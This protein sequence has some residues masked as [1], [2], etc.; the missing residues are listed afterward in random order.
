MVPIATYQNESWKKSWPEGTDADQP[1]PKMDMPKRWFFHDPTISDYQD[2]VRTVETKDLRNVEAYCSALWTFSTDLSE[3]RGEP[4]VHREPA[5][6]TATF[7]FTL[8]QEENVSFRGEKAGELGAFIKQQ[9]ESRENKMT[10]EHFPKSSQERELYPVTVEIYEVTLASNGKAYRFSAWRNF[11]SFREGVPEGV[12]EGG[13]IDHLHSVFQG[14]VLG[15]GNGWV[16][17]H[18]EFK[19]GDTDDPG[20]GGMDVFSF[21]SFEVGGKSYWAAQTHFYEGIGFQ[22]LTISEDAVQDVIN[23]D[24]GGC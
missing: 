1:K 20:A 17:R 4:D 9:L 12:S 16:V 13:V 22:L 14:W 2:R 7:P 19:V 18:E 10:L 21:G 15:K 6:L 8:H 23:F 11:S 5:G 24:I 3:E